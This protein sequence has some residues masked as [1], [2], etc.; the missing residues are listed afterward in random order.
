MTTQGSDASSATS[1]TRRDSEHEEPEHDDREHKQQAAAQDA[2]KRT[3]PSK[4][5]CELDVLES[6]TRA[7][8][9]AKDARDGTR[10]PPQKQRRAAPTASPSRAANRGTV[11]ARQRQQTPERGEGKEKEKEKEKKS[12][13]ADG[14]GEGDSGD[15]R[16]DGDE[17][18]DEDDASGDDDDSDDDDDDDDDSDDDDS[19]DDDDDD[20]SGGD[21]DGDGEGDG[22]GASDTTEDGGEAAGEGQGKDD[23]AEH[24]AS[25][26]R[27]SARTVRWTVGSGDATSG[28]RR[29]TSVRVPD[30]DHDGEFWDFVSGD[31]VSFS[32]PRGPP[33][34]R[35]IGFVGDMFQD[36]ASHGGRVR[37]QCITPIAN[38]DG[39]PSSVRLTH[40][41]YPAAVIT[42]RHVVLR[43]PWRVRTMR[44]V[45]VN[46]DGQKTSMTAAYWVVKN[47]Y[48]RVTFDVVVDEE[49][50]PHED[51]RRAR[52]AVARYEYVRR[53]EMCREGTQD[54][55]LSRNHFT[56]IPHE[57]RFRHEVGY[58]RFGTSSTG[59]AR[60]RG[61]LQQQPA[62]R[63]VGVKCLSVATVR[64]GTDAS[65]D[66]GRCG[67]PTKE[68]VDAAS[69]ESSSSS[70]SAPSAA[71]QK[72]PKQGCAAQPSASAGTN[73]GATAPAGAAADPVLVSVMRSA[74]PV[75]ERDGAGSDDEEETAAAAVA[76]PGSIES[77]DTVAIARRE[78]ELGSPADRGHGYDPE[79][80]AANVYRGLAALKGIVETHI[81]MALP[82]RGPR[83]EQERA[84]TS[85]HAWMLLV[86]LLAELCPT[87]D[88][89]AR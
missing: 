60:K 86:R 83:S 55:Y 46:T 4:R 38:V 52:Y 15:E 64:A 6:M 47:H 61:Q 18:S 89:A 75:P 69:T 57:C 44:P 1:R 29:V 37:I 41:G 11:R 80:A 10:T 76:D 27:A 30:P 87:V 48:A 54:D 82:H 34:T 3:R 17:E 72:E 68:S 32:D 23:T 8:T 36:E 2:S 67:R 56:D 73:A 84:E 21:E 71:E 42:N 43:Q 62:S 25:S 39:V 45:V 26:S 16:A 28:M 50:Q 51:G 7:V 58:A 66:V 20:G 78:R 9:S 49:R 19:D 22:G 5:K 79:E 81:D 70:S 59:V 53:G 65:D 85:L 40:G 33:G 14:D 88:A 63:C 74:V 35:A 13:G 12:R 77:V 24:H 31:C